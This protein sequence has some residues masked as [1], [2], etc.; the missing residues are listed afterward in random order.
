SLW[1]DIALWIPALF[2]AYVFLR[3]GAAKFSDTSG[4]ARA[5]EVW[6]FPVWFRI[7]IGCLE[8][9][10]A[11]LLLTRRTASIGAATIALVMLGGV[12]THIYW[13]EPAQVRSEVLPLTLALIVFLGRRPHA[14]AML[15]RLRKLARGDAHDA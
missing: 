13:G 3:Q 4:W 14:A 7:L 2:L 6:H 1:V 15:A 8:T 5:F 12:G 9:G 10:A 11:A